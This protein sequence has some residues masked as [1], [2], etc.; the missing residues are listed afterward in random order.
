MV[1]DNYT[2]LDSNANQA[3]IDKISFFQETV[4]SF[5]YSQNC[6][7]FSISVTF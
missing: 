3:V 2:I 5:T 6:N 7:L 1:E 4:P